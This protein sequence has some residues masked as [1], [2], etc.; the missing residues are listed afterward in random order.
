MAKHYAGADFYV[1]N[2]KSG[3]GVFYLNDNQARDMLKNNQ[4]GFIYNYAVS[5]KKDLVLVPAL[6]YV[7]S[8]YVLNPTKFNYNNVINLRTNEFCGNATPLPSYTKQVNNFGSG[9]LLKA[10]N[11]NVGCMVNNINKANVGLASDVYL[12]TRVTA[13]GDA[14]FY[15]AKKTYTTNLFF[16][17]DG[18]DNFN[19]LQLGLNNQLYKHLQLGL[20]AATDGYGFASI[21]YGT[22]C[23]NLSLAYIANYRDV[24]SGSAE[25]NLNFNFVRKSSAVNKTDFFR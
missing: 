11:F 21:G 19:R 15:N 4:I 17:Y 1:K 8:S 25:L 9:L 23:V 2:I 10:T 16:R 24:L 18:Q 5:L 22:K 6:Q 3:F 13:H 7:Y 12:K 14:T 20:A